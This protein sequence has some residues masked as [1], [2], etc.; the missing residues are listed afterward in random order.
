MRREPICP[1]RSATW[2]PALRHNALELTCR[3]LLY[4]AARE[5]FE[6]AASE[7]RRGS[8]LSSVDSGLRDM[9]LESNG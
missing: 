6:R 8:C 2:K 1:E 3:R 7:E 5:L 4:D 9:P